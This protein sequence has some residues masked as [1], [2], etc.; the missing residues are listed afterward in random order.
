MAEEASWATPEPLFHPQFSTTEAEKNEMHSYQRG[1][2]TGKGKVKG[3]R[4][5]SGGKGGKG[6]DKSTGKGPASGGKGDSETPM[7]SRFGRSHVQSR[8]LWIE[9][10]NT[11]WAWEGS[12]IR[13]PCLMHCL[14]I[15]CISA[16]RYPIGI[17]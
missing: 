5:D 17:H 6:K 3:K 2:D 13:L 7:W 12:A 9:T 1:L 8:I 11:H 10:Q 14:G 16:A 15:P 4:P